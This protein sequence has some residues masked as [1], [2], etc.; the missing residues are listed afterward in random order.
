MTQSHGVSR[1]KEL[2][3]DSESQ[4][5]SDLA[6]RL[7]RLAE[8]SAADRALVVEELRRELEASGERLERQR[9]DLVARLDVLDGR[10][11]N[12]ERLEASVADILEGAIRKAEIHRHEALAS[13]VAPLVVRTV[14]TEIRNSRDELVEALYPMTGRMVKAYVASAMKDLMEDINRRLEQNPFMLRLASLATG[15]SVAELALAETQRL[16]VKEIYLIRRGTGA[17]VAHWPAEASGANREQVVSGVLTALTEFTSEA[18]SDDGRALRQIDLGPSQVYLRVSPM[19]LLAVRCTGT[20]HASVEAIIDDEFLGALDQQSLLA[21]AVPSGSVN[22]AANADLVASLAGRLEQRIDAKVKELAPPRAGIAALKVIGWA[23]GLPLVL[24]LGWTTYSSYETSRVEGIARNILSN[25]TELRGYPTHV[26]VERRGRSVTVSGLAPTNA[27]KENAVSEITRS[28]PSSVVRDQ[29]AVVPSGL[30]NAEPLVRDVR[31]E[32]A[33][34]AATRQ[35]DAV[36]TSAVRGRQALSTLRWRLEAASAGILNGTPQPALARADVAIENA[37]KEIDGL[38][39]LA[40]T[41]S[42]LDASGTRAERI[43]AAARTVSS[44]I[45]AATESVA[46]IIPAV[47]GERPAQS[48]PPIAADGAASARALEASG[49]PIAA[50]ALVD[51]ETERLDAVAA[52]LLEAAERRAGDLILQSDLAGM[53][54]AVAALERRPL[55]SPAPPP[56]V[57]S[58]RDRLVAWTQANAIFFANNAEPRDAARTERQLTALAELMRDGDDLVRVVGYTDELGGGARNSSLS[59]IR[60]EWV[61]QAL[62]SRG[63]P[64]ARL[65]AIGRLN[66]I[67]IAPTKG[68]QSA[69]RRVEFEVG[70]IG[71]TAP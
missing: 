45:A 11:G 34:L 9:E 18:F 10:V 65:V 1:L 54:S 5:L 51:V 20:A 13:A 37:R 49:G 21:A 24:W 62:V 46:Q 42:A 33:D 26:S 31:R 16:D 61:A 63:V 67:D 29:I 66:A 19:F 3:F 52:A 22:A 35:R 70:F 12:A 36:L 8:T 43:I 56:S 25:S 68:Q 15:R 57:P 71:E 23:V 47:P 28:L 64:P 7:D 4:T 27:A 55:P 41:A 69:N 53:K 32:L 40:S 58:P 60:A 59:Q 50:A 2:L 6:L 38:A 30:A 44:A 17:M 48:A 39:A 14:K